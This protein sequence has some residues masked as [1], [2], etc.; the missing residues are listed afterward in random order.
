L[1]GWNHSQ[2]VRYRSGTQFR[3]SS[4]NLR[5]ALAQRGSQHP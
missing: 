2:P 3:I 1:R 4:V 5:G